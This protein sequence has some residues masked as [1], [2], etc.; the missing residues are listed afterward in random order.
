MA[1]E[2]PNQN[3]DVVFS[4]Q[5]YRIDMAIKGYGVKSGM[6]VTGG[7]AAS[8]TVAVA[9]GFVWVNGVEIPYAGGS[10]NISAADATYPRK[11]LISIDSAGAIQVTEGTP[12]AADPTGDTGPATFAPI[13]PA[14]PS[15]ET[16]LAEV[17]VAAGAVGIIDANIHDMRVIAK[18][19]YGAFDYGMS[20]E[21]T[22]S[23]I[24]SA[25]KFECSNLTGYGNDYFAGY[26][27]YV[28]WDAGGAGAAPQ[29]EK[30]I[31][32]DYVSATGQ[33]TVAAW[34]APLAVG[35]KVLIVHPAI[36]G[37]VIVEVGEMSDTA[38][39]DDLSDIASTSVHAKL[40]RLLL[41]FSANAFAATV[42]GSPRADIEAM[43]TGLAS[44]I[45]AAGAA[46]APSIGGSTRADIDAALAAL[47][48][49]IYTSGHTLKTPNTKIGD[50]ARTL[51]LIIGSRWDSSGDLGTDV[52]TIITAVGTTIPD[53]VAAIPTTAMR[54][55]DNALLASNYTAPDNT[56]IGTINTN[57][58]DAS[59][60]NLTSVVAKLGDDTVTVKA[61]LDAL[62]GAVAAIPTT[63]M[64]GTD[65]A[66]L[67]SDMGT[68]ADD[69]EDATLFGWV[70]KTYDMASA[71]HD[72]AATAAG[73]AD[74]DPAGTLAALVGSPAD[75]DVSTDIANVQAAV[76]A[77]P[78]TAMRGTD[79]AFLASVGGAL[80]TAATY[81][82]AADKT[83]MAYIKGLVASGIAAVGQVDD[84][85]PSADDFDT[86]LTE[87]TDDHYNG[88]KMTFISGALTG[89][90]RYIMDYDG[91][92]KNCDFSALSSWTEAPAD[93]DWFV[94]LPD[95]IYPLVYLIN[96][97]A[98]AA[99]LGELD[100]AAA[101][102]AVSDAKKAMAYI[103]Q[104][105]TAEIAIQA[106]T[107]L[108]LPGTKFATK[109]STADLTSG[110]IFSYTGTVGII[111][112]IG[113][114]TTDIE[115]SAVTVKLT[116]TPDALSAKDICAVKDIQ[117]FVAGTLLSITGTFA[118]ALVATDGEGC[119]P[120]QA[121]MITATCVTSGKIS[122]VFNP[123]ADNSGVIVWEILWIPQTP[124]ATLV[125]A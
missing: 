51:D 83:V 110:D 60:D 70:D 41:R 71:A 12:A 66:A 21:G 45:K 47:D 115:D 26:W 61:R 44:Y 46:F 105:V 106:K 79:N 116:I 88:A 40:S 25:P 4:N 120:S 104:C 43:V 124:G 69:H 64:R 102:G 98:S 18:T 91:T 33:F 108:I 2:T 86:T 95:N 11:D 3:G 34:T 121:S 10:A 39:A 36:M 76:D 58:G 87:A 9:A 103:K 75:T 28:V 27:A 114:I 109:T 54:G 94:I 96:S 90:S 93:E 119:A 50:I 81:A 97:A 48:A 73:H 113:R 74:P 13:P 55:T 5:L 15:D 20:F 37:D 32:T 35:D 78:T 59:E 77:I 107:D 101:T 85:A 38:T 99:V 117:D 30:K 84:V 72:D 100:T 24:A 19:A 57:V 56:T 63:A 16:L 52:G 111:S 6:A 65:S 42:N 68:S 118:D 14:L 67:A 125:A 1:A 82:V 89:Q 80:D 62:D 22:V 122:T 29:S 17:W 31:I 92:A 123:S 8:M 53:A 23:G 112:I 7:G 49:E